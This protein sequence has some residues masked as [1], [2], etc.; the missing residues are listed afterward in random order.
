M[1]P[2]SLSPLFHFP[3]LPLY[4]FPQTSR[5][6][7]RNYKEEQTFQSGTV[8]FFHSYK[9]KKKKKSAFRRLFSLM[10][11]KME[12]CSRTVIPWCPRG[13]ELVPHLPTEDC[14]LLCIQLLPAVSFL[15]Q[16]W[17]STLDNQS[18]GFVL[19]P[20]TLIKPPSLSPTRHISLTCQHC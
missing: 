9:K 4:A 12:P 15:F 18:L 20:P 2:S 8:I 6:I 19:T 10:E 16:L 17:F 1:P 14:F 3:R 5:V 7:N 13:G 11:M